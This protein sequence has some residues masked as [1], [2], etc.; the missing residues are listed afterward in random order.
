MLRELKRL[1]DITKKLRNPIGGCEWDSKQTFDSLKSYTLEETYEVLDAIERQDMVELKS[2]LGD[3]LFQIVFY[4]DL[5]SEQGLFNFDD[6]CQTVA[7]KLVSRHPH[8][9]SNNTTIKPNWEQLKQQER[10]KREQY[11]LLDDIPTAIPALMKAEKIQKRCASVGFDWNELQPVIAKVKEEI[12][13]VEQELVQS[14]IDDQSKVEEEIGDLLFATVN[15]A[16]H[17]KVKSELSLQ[18]ANNKF[19]RRFKQVELLLKQKN[20]NLVDATLE[21]MED[22]WQI[23]KRTEKSTSE[24]NK[25]D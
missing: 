17:L 11:S 14:T 13:E 24:V 23:V 16:R 8:V 25:N 6:I 19:I 9:F 22:A 7:D 2:E 10:D 4:A 1:Q 3:L 20:R 21:E 18:N 12:N 5:A 15:L